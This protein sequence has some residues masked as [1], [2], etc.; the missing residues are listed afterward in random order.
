MNKVTITLVISLSFMVCKGQ[1][2]ICIGSRIEQNIAG[3][4]KILIPSGALVNSIEYT[5]NNHIFTA[6]IRDDK[7]VIY[8][9]TVDPN[10]E[11]DGFKTND[12]IFK[13]YESSQVECVLG[14][15]YY[16]KID[17]EWYAGFEINAKPTK[18][19]KIKWLFKYTFINGNKNLFKK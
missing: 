19:S 11:I 3:T 13:I 18:F 4:S 7:S 16:I 17:S 5:H 6:G 1:E 12:E 9:S 8:I 2:I 14:W 10:F 15:G